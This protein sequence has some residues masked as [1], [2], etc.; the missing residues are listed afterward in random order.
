[1]LTYEYECLSCGHQFEELQKMT[2]KPIEICPKCKGKVRR[3]ISGGGGVLFK[4]KGFYI[5]D[6]RSESYKKK[7]R[8][9]KERSEP[10]LDTEKVKKGSDRK[11][12]IKKDKEK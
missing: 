4:G 3:K 1:M 8:E 10:K 6:H 2:D 5:T 11:T 7:A 12:E 9:E